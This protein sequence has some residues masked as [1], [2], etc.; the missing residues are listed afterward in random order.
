MQMGVFMKATKGEEYPFQ[1]NYVDLFF[2]LLLVLSR[3]LIDMND[4]YIHFSIITL[5]NPKRKIV[6]ALIWITCIITLIYVYPKVEV[7]ATIWNEYL[8]EDYV[9]IK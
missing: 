4:K 7:Y 5:K 3:V 8:N 6:F 9:N 2:L 1:F